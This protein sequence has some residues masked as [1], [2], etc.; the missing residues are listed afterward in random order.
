MYTSHKDSNL[1]VIFY[2]LSFI[3]VRY[4][5]RTACSLMNRQM[6]NISVVI[7]TCIHIFRVG[8]GKPGFL[9][10]A[11][12]SGRR[13]ISADLTDNAVPRPWH[14]C[15]LKRSSCHTA[16]MQTDYRLLKN[17]LTV[18]F[19][20][21]NICKHFMG[22]K[23]K[24]PKFVGMPYSTRNL[25]GVSSDHDNIPLTGRHLSAIRTI[26][27]Y[28][29]CC[30]PQRYNGR[31]LCQA[32]VFEFLHR[33]WSDLESLETYNWIRGF[34]PMVSEEKLLLTTP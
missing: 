24:T 26:V 27:S 31:E 21:T 5:N 3:G 34:R 16:E 2:A 17:D 8:Q 14:Q 18:C 19:S 22:L 10:S 23:Q 9:R 29:P 1:I 6:S 12:C 33:S 20:S 15:I 7:Y 32:Y 4:N 28:P 25:S 11:C 30:I 13:E